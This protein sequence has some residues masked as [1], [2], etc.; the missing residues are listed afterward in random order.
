MA[1][2]APADAAPPS[3]GLRDET[4]RIRQL[5]VWLLG[6]FAAVGAVVVSGLSLTTLSSDWDHREGWRTGLA[7]VG[8]V[9]ALAC[10]VAAIRQTLRVLQAGAV[11]L[12]TL[13][14]LPRPVA[15]ELAAAQPIFIPDLSDYDELAA[16]FI[17]ANAAT[18]RDYRTYLQTIRDSLDASQEPKE[19]AQS[20]A[21]YQ[22]SRNERNLY[23]EQ[24]QAVVEFAENRAVR[25]A[26]REASLWMTLAA[27]GTLV[28]VGLYVAG[29]VKES[30]AQPLDQAQR[31]T[32][33]LTPEGRSAYERAVALAA[34]VSGAE[35]TCGDK[36]QNTFE[37][38]LTRRD[39]GADLVVVPRLSAEC[40]SVELS[41]AEGRGTA[42]P[43]TPNSV[44]EPACGGS[45]I[46]IAINIDGTTTQSSI[47]VPE[48]C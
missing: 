13:G 39:G 2:D 19:L 21:R 29:S 25:F 32:V 35:S 45:D 40:P 27:F 24:G 17:A 9:I 31:V 36:L 26:L 33:D 23:G 3:S 5:A 44:A 34:G 1:E 16:R 37:G 10:V 38:F 30:E 46:S 48:T 15:D 18:N 14:R 22:T 43:V 11:T 42:V 8:L 6:A 4:A 41:L 28:G 20:R 12:P 47:T 7:I